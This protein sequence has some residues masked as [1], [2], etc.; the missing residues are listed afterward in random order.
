[1]QLQNMLQP[2]ML[3]EFKSGPNEGEVVSEIDHVRAII[4][5]SDT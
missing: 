2:V 1:M 5:K 3:F 4:L